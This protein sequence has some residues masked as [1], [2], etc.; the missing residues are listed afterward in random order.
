VAF[1][2]QLFSCPGTGNGVSF[3]FNPFPFINTNEIAALAFDFVFLFNTVIF[4]YSILP[5]V[6]QLSFSNLNISENLFSTFGTLYGYHFRYYTL[7]LIFSCL[8]I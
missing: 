8:K 4:D 3:Q 1:V 2:K 7:L 5:A 6:P